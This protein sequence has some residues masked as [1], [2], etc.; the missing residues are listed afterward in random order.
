MACMKFLFRDSTKG[1]KINEDLPLRD[2]L[3][4]TK[5]PKVLSVSPNLRVHLQSDSVQQRDPF[6]AMRA[7]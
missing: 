2:L 6:P 5:A 4:T 1:N 3:N 7:A